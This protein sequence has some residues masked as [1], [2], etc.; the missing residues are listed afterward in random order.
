MTTGTRKNGDFCWINILTAAPVQARD[1]YSGVLRW[2][3]TEMPGMGHGI[4]VAGK[5]IGALFDLN[6]QNTP[7]GARPTI[8]VMVK[9]ESADAMAA[10]FNANGG[11]ALTP[12]DL[13]KRGRMAV[14]YDPVGANIDLLQAG[15]SAGTDVDSMVH[16]APSW[17]ETITSDV[18]NATK[19]YTTVFG[20]TAE[21][22]PMDGFDYTTFSLDGVPVAGMLPVAHVMDDVKPFWVVYFTVDDVDASVEK[23]TQLGG[24]ICIPATDIPGI[25]RFAGITSPQGITFHTI[26]YAQ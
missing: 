17:Y 26:K 14:A 2:T 25:G 24:S 12:F 18:P 23:A 5:S 1:F 6:G 7:P 10:N 20:W 8:G 19:F 13:G 11:K 3:Y 22:T 21:T 16:G 15:S 4:Q 9:T